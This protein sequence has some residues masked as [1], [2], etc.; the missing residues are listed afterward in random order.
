MRQRAANLML[1]QA[2]FGAKVDETNRIN[3]Q[4]LMVNPYGRFERRALDTQWPN[5]AALGQ[6]M[7]AAEFNEIS[8]ENHIAKLAPL[9]V[10][11][12]AALNV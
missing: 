11:R 5:A 12:P 2:G 8:T 3:S 4:E 7:V 10:G 9:V 1:R 6:Q